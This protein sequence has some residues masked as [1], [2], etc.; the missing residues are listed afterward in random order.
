MFITKELYNLVKPLW[1]N[2][3]GVMYN[4]TQGELSKLAAQDK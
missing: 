4:N 1:E 2:C 3:F